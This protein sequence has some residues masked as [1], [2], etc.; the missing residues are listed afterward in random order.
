MEYWWV[1]QNQTAD[2]E[3]AGGYM[4]SPKRSQNDSYNQF[5][6]NMRSVDA[7]DLVL[8]YYD[9]KIQHLGVVRY[10][11]VSAPKPT[12]FGKIGQNW[13][14]EV[15]Y[16]PVEWA[17]TSSTWTFAAFATFPMVSAIRTA[18]LPQANYTLYLDT[19]IAVAQSDFRLFV[20]PQTLGRGQKS[21]GMARRP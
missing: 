11:A 15:W 12:E 17:L 21:S 5:Y 4:W 20:R 13:S 8:S 3:I 9:T 7:G 1:N 16:V 2:H 18:S 14:N 10:P 19:G 6:E